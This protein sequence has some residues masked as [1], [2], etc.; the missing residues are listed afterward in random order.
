MNIE[1]PSAAPTASP[2]FF[3][4]QFCHETYGW[5]DTFSHTCNGPHYAKFGNTEKCSD[6]LSN[7]KPGTYGLFGT[8][9]IHT[10]LSRRAHSLLTPC[11]LFSNKH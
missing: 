11:G 5:A 4:R 8:V 3:T 1:Q 2:V 6:L 9:S 7:E 10:I